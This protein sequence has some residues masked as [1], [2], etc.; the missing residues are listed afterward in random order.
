MGR[1]RIALAQIDTT[2]GDVEGNLERVAARLEEARA[3]EADLVAFPELVITGYPPED[4][5]L[6]GAFVAANLAA[7]ERLAAR[8][9]GLTAVVGFVERSADLYNAAA[10]LHDGRL[11]GIY[12]KHRLPNYGVFDELRYFRKG[13]GECLFQVC[14]AWV[15]VSIC[16][17]IWS[18]GGPVER[19]ALAGADIVVNLN[20]SPYQ[21]EKWRLRRRMLRTRAADYGVAIA[22]VNQVGGQDE[23]V[24]DGGSLVLDA[25][26]GILAQ[27]AAF[28]EELLLCD[29]ELEQV[30]RARVHDPRRRQMR[31]A[32]LE[33]VVLS[34]EPA[35]G[36]RAPIVPR[37]APE[38]DAVGDVY[39]ALVAGTTGYV[40]KNGF[41]HVVL[42]LSGGIDSALVATMAA[43][44]LGAAAVT[45]VA[46]PS[47]YSS[48]GSVRDARALATA[49]GIDFRTIAIEEI[50]EPTLRTL[51]DAFEGTDPDVTEENIQARIRGLLLMALSNKFGWLVLT[52]GNKSEMATGYATLY[53][54]MAGGFAVLKDVPK[55]LVYALCE[56]RNAQSPGAPPIPRS[57]IEK[58]PSAELRPDQKDSD[59]LP[60]YDVL[61]AILE[62]YVELDWSTAEL[63]EAGF[64]P[65]TVRRVVRLVDISEYKRR[66]APPGVK[67]T[68]R[69]FGKDRR[70]PITSRWRDK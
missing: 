16:E 63:V 65:D 69:A 12:R 23:L 54:D 4:L 61:D 53:G 47:R 21:R 38:R 31:E 57:I 44:A 22:Y 8:T 17:D 50:F 29:V 15:G 26:G 14:G 43:D 24:F 11:A 34:T 55:T 9:R 6:K 1:F 10:V 25:A 18:P 33:R 49:L 32:A 13:R 3:A 37:P 56:W 30:F 60:P 68:G 64:D 42:G 40:R 36:V 5:L 48:E 52:T 7:V 27:A 39:A 28:E 70:L 41:Q 66:Q 51:K 62:R 45:G 67:I 46:L 35:P 58:P 59:S 2:V 19:M 20:A